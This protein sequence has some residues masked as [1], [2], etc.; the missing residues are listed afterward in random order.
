MII[1]FILSMTSSRAQNVCA[2][3]CHTKSLKDEDIYK[4]DSNKDL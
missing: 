4:H 2:K 1:L 3:I